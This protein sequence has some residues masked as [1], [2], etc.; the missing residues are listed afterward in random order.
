MRTYQHSLQEADFALCK[1]CLVL[2]SWCPVFHIANFVAK[3]LDR[4]LCSC[5]A[6][7]QYQEFL[8]AV[9]EEGNV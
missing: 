3:L 2:T 9:A 1:G 4:F 8:L 5:L 6:L 7:L